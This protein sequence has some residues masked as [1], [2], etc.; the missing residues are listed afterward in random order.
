V[1]SGFATFLLKKGKAVPSLL[2][3]NLGK[4]SGELRDG[5][6]TLEAMHPNTNTEQC[7]SQP[8]ENAASSK[9]SG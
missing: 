7:V 4:E 9:E 3:S 5:N 8:F 6:C 2:L 1:D